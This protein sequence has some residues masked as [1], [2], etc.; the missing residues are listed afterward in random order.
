MPKV[1]F[2][3]LYLPY[4]FIIHLTEGNVDLVRIQST[5]MV[6]PPCEER[7]ARDADTIR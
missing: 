2:K 3:V 7:A 5:T 6:N 1:M 4:R